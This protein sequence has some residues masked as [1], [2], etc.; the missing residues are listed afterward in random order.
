MRDNLYLGQVVLMI[1]AAPRG[2]PKI[3][4]TVEVQWDGSVSVMVEEEMSYSKAELDIS[5][6]ESGRRDGGWREDERE[7]GTLRYM[8]V[9]TFL[10]LIIIIQHHNMWNPTPY[11]IIMHL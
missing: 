8:W 2:M 4:A 9:Q 11:N 6:V 5:I 1:A 7:R 3:S 10:F